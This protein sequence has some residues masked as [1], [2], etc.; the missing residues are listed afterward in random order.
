MNIKNKFLSLFFL[1]VFY[2]SSLAAYDLPF[3]SPYSPEDAQTLHIQRVIDFLKAE[4]LNLAKKEIKAFL[5]KYPESEHNQSLQV[6]AG[7]LLFQEERYSQSYT[8]YSKVK[9]LSLFKKILPNFLHAL[10]HSKQYRLLT[11]HIEELKSQDHWKEEELALMNFYLAESLLKRNAEYFSVNAEKEIQRA[12]GLYSSLDESKFTLASLE[13]LAMAHELLKQQEKAGAYLKKLVDLDPENKEK[14]LFSLATL[15]S[16]FN[17]QEAL[18]NYGKV[19]AFQGP[20]LSKALFNKSLILFNLERYDDIISLHEIAEHSL[21]KGQVG[22][23]QYL[24]GRSYYFKE[25]FEEAIIALEKASKTSL[26]PK[27][28]QTSYLSLADCALKTQNQDLIDKIITEYTQAFPEDDH[29]AKF[30]LVKAMITKDSDSVLAIKLYEKLVVKSP[31]F[32]SIDKALLDLASLYKNQRLYGKSRKN[33]LR[34]IKVHPESFY[35]QEALTNLININIEQ[36]N[37]LNQSPDQDNS[38]LNKRFI[39]DLNLALAHPSILK[40][41]KEALLWLGKLYSDQEEYSLAIENLE[42]FIRKYPNEKENFDANLLLS[43]CYEKQ[44]SHLNRYDFQAKKV[45]PLKPIWE[46]KFKVHLNLFNSYLQ[47]LQEV[48]NRNLS[49]SKRSKEEIKYQ[50]LMAMNLLKSLAIGKKH[51]S[52]SNLF[53]L[54]NFHYRPLSKFVEENWS[55][56]LTATQ[57][58]EAQK[59]IKAF[60]VA[61]LENQSPM[62][63]EQSDLIEAVKLSQLYGWLALNSKKVA[64]LKNLIKI[65][66]NK[67]EDTQQERLIVLFELAR[68]SENLG[69]LEE[70]KRWYQLVLNEDSQSLSYFKSFSQLHLSKIALLETP[71]EERNDENPLMQSLLTTLKSLKSNKSILLEPLHLEAAIS[72]AEIKASLKTGSE[73]QSELLNLLKETKQEFLNED[74]I[75]SQD[76]HLSREKLKKQDKIFQAYMMYFDAKINQIEADLAKVKQGN[77]YEIQ[78]KLEASASIYQNITNGSFALTPY[79][80]KKAQQELKSLKEKL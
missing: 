6:L 25:N 67:S 16:E 44:K 4:E 63:K 43:F 70:A 2:T 51:L 75:L 9:E 36:V 49:S 47:M 79:L 48:E 71:L 41:K 7:D 29:V 12:I 45:L 42:N 28:L 17:K 66:Q 27:Q 15:Q 56:P 62:I 5:E 1:C 57:L 52:K 8:Y 3:I 76:Y 60:E 10:H 58:Q 14:H 80:H 65:T 20:F 77:P 68:S 21:E 50:E 78:T 72:Y 46:Q 32:E 11:K 74:D 39:K 61:L 23:F 59:A 18:I 22:Y 64:L 13:G 40:E 26:A 53:W 38:Y 30:Q 37:S 35:L 73:N 54:A 31:H 55:T 34:L 33:L 24:L 69:L 19:I